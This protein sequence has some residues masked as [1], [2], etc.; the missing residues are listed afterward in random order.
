MEIH[1]VV[2]DVSGG[3][4]GIHIE[5]DIHRAAERPMTYIQ[6]VNEFDIDTICAILIDSIARYHG[7]EDG[8]KRTALMTAIFTYRVNGVHFKATATMNKQFD[9]LVMWV[10]KKKPGVSEIE[11]RLQKLRSR[12]EVDTEQ[13]VSNMFLSFARMRLRKEATK[14]SNKV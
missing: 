1:D 13:P 9:A 12:F 14:R 5:N 3:R 10:V 6:Y 4:A 7:F 11:K 2:L 8:N